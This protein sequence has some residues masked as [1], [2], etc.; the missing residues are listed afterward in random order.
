MSFSAFAL[1]RHPFTRHRSRVGFVS[2]YVLGQGLL[3]V[4]NV[5]NGFFLLRWLS[6]DEQAKFSLA[7][8]LQAVLV[9]LADLGFGG[10][11]LG[12]IGSRTDD[13]NR[14]G[15][16]VA[17]VRRFKNQFFGICA[18][19]VTLVV[20][21]YAAGRGWT[22]DGWLLYGV[23]LMGTY[24]QSQSGYYAAVLL[25]KRKLMA[26]YQPQILTAGL[27]LAVSFW[28][29]YGEHLSALAAVLLTTGAFVLNALS[30]R[31]RAR[32][33]YEP[34]RKADRA[35]RREMLRT[36]GPV[37]PM[38][39][40][41]ALQGQLVLFLAGY[42]GQATNVAQIGALGRINQLFALLTP[43]NAIVLLPYFA[44]SPKTGLVRRYVLVLLAGVGVV[45]PV[46]AVAYQMP[47]L[48]VWLLGAKYASLRDVLGP[49]VLS[50]AVWY[51]TSIAWAV[52]A[53]KNWNHWTTAA[54]YVLLLTGVQM[55]G[56]WALDLS[57][58]DQLVRLNVYLA[59]GT[60]L[61]YGLASV[62][63]YRRQQRMISAPYR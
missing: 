56:L 8:G 36:L 9:V 24:A 26:F 3:Q 6:I 21:V 60:L 39:I 19:V 35:I 52:N 14:I 23:V 22:L 10:S 48:F 29:Y 55:G 40:F 28:L 2:D 53:A 42:F 4:L 59:G 31:R 18:T 13:R 27:R 5:L 17:G 15:Q 54:L 51:L 44:Q 37:M 12:L 32:P 20:A 41:Y 25:M 33:Y 1:L 16:Y 49:Y 61:A 34:V 63:G 62:A 11:L 58:T 50:A 7:M 43:F 45:L 46:V 47:V 38:V 57:R 30:M